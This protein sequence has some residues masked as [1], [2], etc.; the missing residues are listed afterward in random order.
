MKPFRDALTEAWVSK[1]QPLSDDIYGGKMEG[2]VKCVDS[3]YNGKRSSSWTFLEGKKNAIVLGSTNSKEIV[4]EN[5][6]ATGV[7]VILPDGTEAT[8]K[9]KYEVIVSSGVFESPKLLM[10]SGIG[11]KKELEAH[12]IKAK[13]E[14]EHVGQNLL[15]HPILSHVFKMKDGYGL[16]SHLLRAGPQHDGA[17]SAYRWK[18]SG[19][20]TSGLL[21]LVAFPRI[22]KEL[23]TSK[24]YNEYLKKNG[25]VDPFGPG[26]QPHF[27]IDFVVGTRH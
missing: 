24:E 15:D 12:G 26:G 8:F 14:S 6:K 3:I 1:G 10:L 13:V 18:N 11:P 20:Y 27:E 17:V 9:A 4:I 16:D 19:P 5:G 7:T 23:A 21:E 22:D 2:L 25:G